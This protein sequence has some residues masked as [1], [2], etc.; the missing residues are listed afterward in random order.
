MTSWE[1]VSFLRM[2]LLYIGSQSVSITFLKINIPFN[3]VSYF[4]CYVCVFL[5][6]CMF[7]SVYSVCVF[8]LLCVFCFVYSVCVFLLLCVFCSVHSVFI[9]PIGTHRLPWQRVF[10]A[11]SSIVWQMPGYN[12]QRR[13][14]ARTLPKL[15]ILFFLLFVCKCVL[16]YCQRVSIQL[17]LTIMSLSTILRRKNSWVITLSTLKTPCTRWF[18]YDRD[19]FFLK[20]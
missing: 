2:T 20:P 3:F 11:F 9:V 1:P 5:L 12:S 15:I 10:P 7:C 4:Y 17:Q 16:Y 19:W 6:L 18:K 8:L 13:G 14:T